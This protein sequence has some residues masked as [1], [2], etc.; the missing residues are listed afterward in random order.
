MP[1]ANLCLTKISNYYQTTSRGYK[2]CES[3]ASLMK[4]HE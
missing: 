1:F 4:T 3:W 2:Y